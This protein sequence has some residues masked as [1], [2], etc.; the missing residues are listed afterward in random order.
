MAKGRRRK[1]TRKGIRQQAHLEQQAKR[2]TA[3][4]AAKP[5]WKSESPRWSFRIL[6]LEGPYGWERA[7]ANDLKAV[8]ARLGHFEAMKWGELV[9]QP[10]NPNHLV[11]VDDLGREARREFERIFHPQDQVDELMSL[12]LDARKRVWG[13][14][15]HDTPALQ[16]LWWDPEHQVCPSM[17]K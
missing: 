7:S 1:R 11:S 2:R 5:D 12:R 6:E 4:A 13:R 17:K 14:L 10:G 8:A 3:T 16:L 15:D 9:T